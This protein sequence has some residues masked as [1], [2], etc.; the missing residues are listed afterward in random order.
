M[1]GLNHKNTSL[2]FSQ[3]P[4]Y[5][6]L[7]LKA[8]GTNKNESAA[9]RLLCSIYLCHREGICK[10]SYSTLVLFHFRRH[11]MKEKGFPLIESLM[12]D[13]HDMVKRAATE[14]MCNMVLC[15]EVTTLFAFTRSLVNY[16]SVDKRGTMGPLR[17]TFMLTVVR[18]LVTLML[19]QILP[20]IT[21]SNYRSQLGEL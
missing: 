13:E 8:D 15:E 17:R 21:T 18:Y 20:I 4:A 11:I 3:S 5:H 2:A 10:V 6:P 14:C 9:K 1:L 12:F 19:K 7:P 16:D